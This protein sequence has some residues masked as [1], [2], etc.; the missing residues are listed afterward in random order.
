M[1]M[2]KPDLNEV[3]EKIVD[4]AGLLLEKTALLKDAAQEKARILTQ[5]AKIRAEVSRNG[6]QLARLYA[7]LGSLYYCMKKDDPDE[8]MKQI[9]EEITVL[10]DRNEE[11][12][13]LLAELKRIEDPA[14][15]TDPQGDPDVPEEASEEA[16]GAESAAEE[17][18]SDEAPEQPL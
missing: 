13:G 2:K 3:R 18:E 7:D 12:E 6:G 14:A 1:D 16:S 11:L 8:Q 10:L 5:K 4:T 9:C 17:Q 15:E